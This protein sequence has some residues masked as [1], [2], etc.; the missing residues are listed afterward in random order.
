L[1][2]QNFQDFN[3]L[4]AVCKNTI[5]KFHIHLQLSANTISKFHI[6]LQLFAKT[7]FQYSQMGRICCPL[8]KVIASLVMSLLTKAGS[9][10]T[11]HQAVFDAN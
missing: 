4:A 9:T 6:H 8:H 1:Q 11:R 2:K 3:L 5:S 7:E 10:L